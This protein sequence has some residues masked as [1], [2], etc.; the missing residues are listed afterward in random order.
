MATRKQQETRQARLKGA[1]GGILFFAAL[2]GPQLIVEWL[3]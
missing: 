2:I 3:K 1:L